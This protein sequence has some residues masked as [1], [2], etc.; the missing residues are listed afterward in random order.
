MRFFCKSVF[1]ATFVVLPGG[2]ILSG[3]QHKQELASCL[4]V[5]TESEAPQSGAFSFLPM[6]ITIG[7]PALAFCTITFIS[8]RLWL[9]KICHPFWLIDWAC[10][11]SRHPLRM[12]YQKVAR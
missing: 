10:Q 12:A 5:C 4:S 7:I 11:S 9:P 8:A 1:F 2:Y 3:L 6:G